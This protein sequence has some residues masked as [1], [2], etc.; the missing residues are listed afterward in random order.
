[1]FHPK[2]LLKTSFGVL[3]NSKMKFDIQLNFVV[4]CG[5]FHL[6]V[7]SKI[8]RFFSFQDFEDSRFYLC[9]ESTEGERS[10]EPKCSLFTR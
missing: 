10:D 1:M 5:F 6:H 7:L 2:P 4:K 8:K 9:N 3:L